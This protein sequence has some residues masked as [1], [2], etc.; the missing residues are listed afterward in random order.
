MSSQGDE[1]T[2]RF[3]QFETMCSCWYCAIIHLHRHLLQYPNIMRIIDDNSQA[4][5]VSL[6]WGE[7]QSVSK[8]AGWLV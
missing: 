7:N 5:M 6:L 1:H 4:A 8:L 3:W 2:E